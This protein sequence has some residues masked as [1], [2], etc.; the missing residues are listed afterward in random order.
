MNTKIKKFVNEVRNMP[1]FVAASASDPAWFE[2]L[3]AMERT[4]AFV[5]RQADD[6]PRMVDLL[7]KIESIVG[8]TDLQIKRRLLEVGELL[9]NWR[10]TLKIVN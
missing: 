9:R 3:E 8:R 1:G 4:F 6:D 5:D 2:H 7:D 10:D